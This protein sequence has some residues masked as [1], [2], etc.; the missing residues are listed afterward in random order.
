M[1]Y[2]FCH[3]IVIIW[4]ISEPFDLTN[5][6]RSVYDNVIFEQIKAVFVRSSSTLHETMDLNSLF[7]QPFMLPT[8]ISPLGG[9]GVNGHL[10]ASMAASASFN[11]SSTNNVTVTATSS[12][13][14]DASSSSNSSASSSADTSSWGTFLHVVFTVVLCRRFCRLTD[15]YLQF[16]IKAHCQ[17]PRHSGGSNNQVFIYLRVNQKSFAIYSKES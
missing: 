5:T 12:S 16:V 17:H 14:T 11:T 15:S 6:A 7:E 10:L 4:W 9:G 1:K 2:L 13:V 3:L 8:S